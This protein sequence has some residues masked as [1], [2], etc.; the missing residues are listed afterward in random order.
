MLV[1]TEFVGAMGFFN[2][3]YGGT[4]PW[5]IGRPQ[6][7]FVR[8]AEAGEI[9]GSVLDAGCGT[10]ENA[11]F[12]AA[13][14]HEVM[15]I[16]S[17]PAAI[18]KAQ[19]K[20]RDR[21]LPAAFAVHDALRLDRLGRTFDTVIDSGLFH[22]FDDIERTKWT[23]SLAAVLR[24]TGAYFLMCFSER[25]PGLWGPRRVTREEIQGTFAEGW[26]VNWIREARFEANLEGDGAQAWL[27]SITR[28][29]NP[30]SAEVRAP[31]VASVPPRT[32]AP[33]ARR[34]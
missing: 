23:K 26:R 11:L 32:R 33:R 28:P 6:R 10:G 21:G 25:E 27:A 17:A 12:L 9:R 5:D 14:G 7:E 24:P 2:T 15:G 16:D 8:L 30:R 13:E 4:P 1:G 19:A 18:E 3:A 22:T 31:G 34:R 20:A 29:A